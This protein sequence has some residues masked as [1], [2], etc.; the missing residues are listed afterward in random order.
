MQWLNS[1]W[2]EAFCPSCPC[3]RI[4]LHPN[5]SGQ[6]DNEFTLKVM[7][8]SPP[9]RPDNIYSLFLFA[10]L[11]KGLPPRNRT[12]T[13]RLPNIWAS[14]TL[15]YMPLFTKDAITNHPSSYWTKQTL[16]RLH[17]GVFYKQYA[18]LWTCMHKCCKRLKWSR[19]PSE[20]L[21]EHPQQCSL[22]VWTSTDSFDTN[23]W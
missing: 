6:F 22:P 13:V 5:T 14:G 10:V 9:M 12:Y 11:V 7:K 18:L 23:T 21:C 19:G 3:R 20:G 15:T 2:F 17:D 4:F 16:M 8:T 1:I